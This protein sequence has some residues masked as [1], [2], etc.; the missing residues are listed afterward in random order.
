MYIEVYKSLAGDKKCSTLRNQI[1]SDGFCSIKC[2]QS[3]KVMLQIRLVNI[4]FSR[5]LIRV[6]RLTIVNQRYIVI[7]RKL[8]FS[9][10]RKKIVSCN[11]NGRIVRFERASWLNSVSFM[12]AMEHKEKFLA[13]YFTKLLLKICKVISVGGSSQNFLLSWSCQCSWNLSFYFNV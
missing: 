7:W 6:E 2:I 10:F 12:K 8:A 13:S 3:L 5:H 4:G 9:Y 1:N 11:I